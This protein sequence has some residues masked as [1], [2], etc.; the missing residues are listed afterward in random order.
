MVK[1][2]TFSKSHLR[3]IV[4]KGKDAKPSTNRKVLKQKKNV[5]EKKT[6]LI[7]MLSL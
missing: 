3:K 4:G 7:F 5:K 1:L 6:E 2:E